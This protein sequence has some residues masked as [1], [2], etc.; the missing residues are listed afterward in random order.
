[1]VTSKDYLDNYVD[2]HLPLISPRTGFRLSPREPFPSLLVL[3]SG[4]SR[5]TFS[6]LIVFRALETLPLE[7]T[8]QQKFQNNQGSQELQ[9]QEV[10]ASRTC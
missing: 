7:G 3:N 4:L 9:V 8:R 2:K 10:A 5:G 6:Y 1:M